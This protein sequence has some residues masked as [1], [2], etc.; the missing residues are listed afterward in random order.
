MKRHKYNRILLNTLLILMLIVFLHKGISFAKISAYCHEL[1]NTYAFAFCD[2]VCS[3]G[4][5][6]RSKTTVDCRDPDTP[7][8][9]P[10]LGQ[11]C[12]HFVSCSIGSEPHSTYGGQ[13]PVPCRWGG[14]VYGEPSAERLYAWLTGDPNLPE[15]AMLATNMVGG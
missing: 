1:A 13:L 10:K 12:A 7:R 5:F 2:L 6:F 11:D 8:T 15:Y 14:K 9:C 3:D 4:C